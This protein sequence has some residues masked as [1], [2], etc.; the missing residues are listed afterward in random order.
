MSTS[1][2]RI[3][4]VEL[5]VVPEEQSESRTRNPLAFLRRRRIRRHNRVHNWRE[6][7]IVR[8]LTRLG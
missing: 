1:A 5:R 6:E 7:A 2:Y 3:R 4:H 8:S